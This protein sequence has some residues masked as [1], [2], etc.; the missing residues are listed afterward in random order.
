MAASR[1]LAQVTNVSPPRNKAI[2]GVNAFAHEAGIHQHGVLQNRATYEIMKPEDIG[3]STDGIVLGKHS[4]RHALGCAR[5]ELGFVLEGEVSTRRSTASSR[6]PT[7]SASST[8]PGWSA[9]W[10]SQDGQDDRRWTLSQLEIRTPHAR[11][12]WPVARVELDHG[13]RGRVTDYRLGAGALDAI[14]SLDQP[15]HGRP[16]AG[17]R[18]RAAI[19]RRRSGRSAE[20][21]QG[22]KVLVEIALDVGGEIFSGRAPRPRH[23]ALLRRRLHRR[24]QQCRDRC[25]E[26]ATRGPAPGRVKG[27]SHE[28]YRRSAG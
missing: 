27:V 18:A 26:G 5:R 21:G 23:P 22:A 19:C 12:S 4:G 20:D 2:V 11:Q 1:T 25:N 8:A 6:S 16:G 7:R 3:L 28:S 24:G 14:F 13:T 9:C 17:R 15:D 10:R